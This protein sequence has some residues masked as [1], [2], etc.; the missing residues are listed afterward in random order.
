[1]RCVNCNNEAIYMV[2]NTPLCHTCQ[3]AFKWGQ[4]NSEATMEP[5]Q[6]RAYTAYRQRVRL[7]GATPLYLNEWQNLIRELTELRKR[8]SYPTPRMMDIEVA[9]HV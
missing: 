6:D 9:L 3:T 4:A 5:V 1:M 7:D 2:G 8:Y